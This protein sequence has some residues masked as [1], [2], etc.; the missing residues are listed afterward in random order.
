MVLTRITEYSFNF[1][2]QEYVDTYLDYILNK[3]V[4]N[5]YG[6][7]SSGFLHVCGGRVLDLFH[8]Q[9]LMDMVIGDENYDWEEFEK[10]GGTMWVYLCVNCQV[11]G[12]TTR[13]G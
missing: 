2:R 12:K 8:P 10:V 6:A 3:S 4:Q 5:Q 9:E 11:L 7:F 13:K 1:H